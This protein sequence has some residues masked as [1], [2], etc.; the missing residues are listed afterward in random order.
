MNAAAK[1]IHQGNLFNGQLA[2]MH[3]SK[4]MYLLVFLLLTVLLSALAVVYSTNAYRLTFSQLEQEQQQAHH[5][6]LQRGQLLLEQTSLATPARVQELAI[7][8]LK[9][10]LPSPK[11]TYLLH[12][13]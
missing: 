10:V 11:N 8:K 9:M 12:A 6:E 13:R 3:L 5:L 2:S 1:V 7:D 4:S